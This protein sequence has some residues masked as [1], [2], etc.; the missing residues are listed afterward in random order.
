MPTVSSD[1]ALIQ[2]KLHDS[3]SIWTRAELLRWYNDG[4][5]QLLAQSGA[6]SRILPLDVPGRHTYACLY[7]WEDRHVTGTYW[8]PGLT[9]YTGRRQVMFA[10]EAEFLEEG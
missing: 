6:F 9:T 5:R 4:Y 7:P 3:A 8:F 2:E 1:L 10:W